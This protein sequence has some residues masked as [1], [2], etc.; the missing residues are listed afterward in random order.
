MRAGPGI[1]ST[2]RA[3]LLAPLVGAV[4]L[5]RERLRVERDLI[6]GSHPF[7]VTGYRVYK[8]ADAEHP[9]RVSSEVIREVPTRSTYTAVF[10]GVMET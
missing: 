9:L 2:G 7:V 6:S 1:D 3:G 4:S 8:S 5:L 10:R